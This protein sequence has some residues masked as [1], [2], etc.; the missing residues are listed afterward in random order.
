L[1]DVSIGAP[2]LLFRRPGAELVAEHFKVFF[3]AVE[4]GFNAR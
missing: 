2:G 3:G 1:I 4:L